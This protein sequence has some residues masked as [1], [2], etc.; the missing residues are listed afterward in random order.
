MPCPRCGGTTVYRLRG[1]WEDLP[2]ESPNK[3]RLAPPNAPD[4]R[5]WLGVLMVVAGVYLAA[6]SEVGYGLLVALGGLL[7]GVWMTAQV[8]RYRMTLAEYNASKIC[9]E[10]RHVF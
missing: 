5:Q 9:M 6:T 2:A 10:N 3:A 1:Y 4:V 8:H 7:W